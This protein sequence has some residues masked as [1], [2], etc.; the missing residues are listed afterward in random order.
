MKKS[1]LLTILTALTIGLIGCGGGDSSNNDTPLATKTISGVAVDGYIKEAVVCLDINEN[2][3]C[4][5]D[6]PSTK[7]NTDG[8]YSLDV[9]SVGTYPI[10]MSGGIDTATN[11]SF[12]GTLKEMVEL[13]ENTTVVSAKITPLTTVATNIYK[14]NVKLNMNYKPSD[15]KQKLATNLG[16]TL[17]Q[18]DNDPM[19]DTKLFTKTQEVVQS[20]QLLAASLDTNS[21]DAFDHVV[22][23]LSITLDESTEDLNISK[24]VEKLESTTYDDITVSID[25]DIEDYV[26]QHKEQIVSKTENI[27][28]TSTL[29]ALQNNIN[30]YTKE[31]TSKINNGVTSSLSTIIDA[32]TNDET[33]AKE[34]T[35]TSIGLEGLTPPQVPTL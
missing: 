17:S 14:E 1:L 32:L 19:K 23:Q 28:D 16:L 3:K 20:A 29:S 13:D 2:D 4:D 26:K 10:I 30:T 5:A 21:T 33:T 27:T 11:E 24:V 9:T 34:N 22:E 15:A 6:E 35:N 8:I 18:V 7:T 31:A 12:V 25:S